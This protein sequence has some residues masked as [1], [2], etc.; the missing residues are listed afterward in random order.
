M[1]FDISFQEEREMHAKDTAYSVKG[2][3]EKLRATARRKQS[4]IA[5]NVVLPCAKNHAFFT[6]IHCEY[7]VFVDLMYK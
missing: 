1:L 3:D 6:S 5:H 4:M 2:M 7:P